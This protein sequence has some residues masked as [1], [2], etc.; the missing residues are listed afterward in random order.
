[1]KKQRTKQPQKHVRKWNGKKTEKHPK[2]IPKRIPKTSKVCKN[3]GPKMMASNDDPRGGHAAWRKEFSTNR[4]VSRFCL[5]RRC[6]SIYIY[7]WK[8]IYQNQLSDWGLGRLRAAAAACHAAVMLLQCC[9]NAFAQ[10]LRHAMRLLLPLTA[11]ACYCLLLPAPVTTCACYCLR[12][13]L[14]AASCA[15]LILRSIKA[16]QQLCKIPKKDMY[17]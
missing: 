10:Q 16:M 13:L 7:I 11:C 15:T 2:W 5:Y 14:P 6:M 1:M 17:E 8:K 9:C 4:P 3:Q 12:L